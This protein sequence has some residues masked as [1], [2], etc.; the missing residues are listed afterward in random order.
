[1]VA[2]RAGV[3]DA[4]SLAVARDDPLGH[5]LLYSPA[6]PI[7]IERAF[8]LCQARRGQSASGDLALPISI[9]LLG[10]R[11]SRPCRNNFDPCRQKFERAGH[12]P[13]AVERHKKF[14]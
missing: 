8:W 14:R 11:G 13:A 4:D 1:M 2:G 3:D 6:A 12:P 10:Q 7:F 5:T 9:S